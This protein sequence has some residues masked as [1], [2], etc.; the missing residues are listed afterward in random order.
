MI[1]EPREEVL[2][3]SYVDSYRKV[4]HELWFEIF[5]KMREDATV[6]SIREGIRDA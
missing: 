2:H 1:A 3:K 5:F 4:Y 6:T